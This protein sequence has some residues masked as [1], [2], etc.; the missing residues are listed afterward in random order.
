MWTTLAVGVAATGVA[1]ALVAGCLE[2]ESRRQRR[3]GAG[4]LALLYVPLLVPQIGF[5]F[6]VQVLFLWLGLA[7]GWLALVWSHLLFVLPYVF[8]TL[9]DPYRSLDGRYARIALALGKPPWLVWLRIKLVML[10]RPV[11]IAMAVGFAVS[12]AQFL[13]TLF[14]GGGRFATLATETLSLAGGGDRRIV[15]TFGFALAALPFAAFALALA[16]STWRFRHRRAL[17][18]GN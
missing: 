2:N 15:G 4:A 11:L 13:P 9:A 7:D 16:V 6:G 17:R 1:I 3:P 5:L 8:L 12:V 18:V 10:L 14:A